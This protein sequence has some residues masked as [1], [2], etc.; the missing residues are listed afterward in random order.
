MRKH[1]L[2]TRDKRFLISHQFDNNTFFEV[3]RN[4][5]TFTDGVT[6]SAVT[7]IAF[8]DADLQPVLDDESR[9]IIEIGG[10]KSTSSHKVYVNEDT[11][12]R[13]GDV[14]SDNSGS[15]KYDVLTVAKYDDHT[16]LD[17]RIREQ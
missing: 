1:I 10:Q 15:T 17:V 3:T 16:E 14:L 6:V 8:Y 12:L 11:L 7:S 13:V 4:I 9:V 2:D 5:H